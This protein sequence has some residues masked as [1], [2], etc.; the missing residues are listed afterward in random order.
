MYGARISLTVGFL[1]VSAWCC[2]RAVPRRPS[3]ASTA[4]WLDSVIMRLADVFLAFPYI[5]FAILLLS[6]LPPG[7]RGHLAR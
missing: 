7:A 6:V 3:P 2:H 4:A 1:A 5:L